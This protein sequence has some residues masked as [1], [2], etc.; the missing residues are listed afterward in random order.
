MTSDRYLPTPSA[1]FAAVAIGYNTFVRAQE[2]LRYDHDYRRVE[3]A[4]G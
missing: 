2:I 4:Q 1:V 3:T